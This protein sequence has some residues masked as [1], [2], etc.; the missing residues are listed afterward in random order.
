MT[1]K[2]KNLKFLILLISITINAQQIQWQKTF[3]GTHA[4]YLYDAMPT[5]DYGFIMVGGSL[6][7]NSG[8]VGKSEGDYDYFI[9]KVSE[10]GNLEWTTT[11]GGEK[12]DVIKSITNTFDGGYLVAGTSNSGKLN[13]KT[14]INIGMQDIWLVKVSIEG[15]IE[16]QKT[17]GGL[18][19]EDVLDVV[20]T[21]EGGF[22]IAGT[23]ASD[24]DYYEKALVDNKELLLKKGVNQGNLDYWLV[25]IDQNGKEVWQKSFGSKYKDVLKKVVEL[26]SGEI[27][28]A[29]SSNSPMGASKNTVNRGL[30][31]WWVLKLDTKG[32]SLWQKVFGEDGDDQLYS[33]LL[34][35][36]D[37]LL[38]GGNFRTY[39]KDGSGD[40][41]FVLKKIDFEGNILWE[42]TYS[43]GDNDVLTDIVQNKDGSLLL[44]GYCSGKE[45][46]RPKTKDRRQA[47]PKKGTEDFLVLKIGAD[48]EEQWRKNIGTDKKE[49]L[50]KS[51]ETRDGGYVLMGTSMPVKARGKNNANF[52]I[53][54]LLDNDK[55]KPKKLPL[56]AIPNPT[57]DYTQIIIG[58]D[59][60]YG[61]VQVSDYAGKI[62]QKFKIDG[63]RIVPVR[64]GGY[65]DGAY[66][67]SVATDVEMNSA[68]VIKVGR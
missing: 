4:D 10:Y 58:E 29:G 26:P 41:D 25:K 9:T 49:V 16:W 56:E 30:A 27:V 8:D 24:G 54:K 5:L 7:S 57:N 14:A 1:Y 53:V 60:K 13:N 59:Y 36:D 6:S 47:I 39:A 48:G 45:D 11:L 67:I 17:L 37:N 43:E 28:L 32:N 23:S 52:Y 35:K 55:E 62:L 12:S 15:A 22:L 42:N 44:S 51:I 33:L 66:I 34:T 50:K 19:N 46:G 20:K 3:G 21:K 64:L 2:M 61:V 38:I 68:K 65:P 31:D 40:S 63:K 18:A